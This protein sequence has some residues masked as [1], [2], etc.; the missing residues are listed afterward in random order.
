MHVCVLAGES[1]WEEDDGE[2]DNEDSGSS[3]GGPLGGGSGSGDGGN[4]PGG[5]WRI[6]GIDMSSLQ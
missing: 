6:P 5:G 4:E 2:D 3:G 1:R